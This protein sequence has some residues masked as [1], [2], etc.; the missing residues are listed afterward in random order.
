MLVARDC[1]RIKIPNAHVSYLLG[2]EI[3]MATWKRLTSTDHHET[4]VN[5]EQIAYMQRDEGHTALI[6]AVATIDGVCSVNITETP[7]QI[8]DAPP[9]R[10]AQEP[11]GSQQKR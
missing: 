5:I 11:S 1:R 7:N 3:A 8:L 6:F 4:Y 2:G 10:S 9:L